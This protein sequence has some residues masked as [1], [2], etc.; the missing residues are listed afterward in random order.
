MLK[1]QE[2]IFGKELRRGGTELSST[3]DTHHVSKGVHCHGEAMFPLAVFLVV[4]VNHFYILLPQLSPPSF[5]ILQAQISDGLYF[6]LK[7]NP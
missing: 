2:I 1:G 5:F 6:Y 7:P 4:L 3:Y